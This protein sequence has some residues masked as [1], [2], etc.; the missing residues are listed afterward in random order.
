MAVLPATPNLGRHIREYVLA[1]GADF[2]EGAPVL[3]T[4]GEVDEIA[5]DGLVVAGFALHDAGADPDPTVCLVALAKGPQSTFTIGGTRAPLLADVGNDF[6]LVK[7]AS[8][9]WVLDLSE[10]TVAQCFV[11]RVDLVNE[12]FEVSILE[13]H[14]QFE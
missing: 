10:T 12:L 9:I 13:E 11:E 1:D 8:G 4:N 2:L 14:R 7:D 3:I 6:G 5:T